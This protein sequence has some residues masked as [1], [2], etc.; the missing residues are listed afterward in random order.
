M[1]HKGALNTLGN[2]IAVIGTGMDIVYPKENYDLYAQ[3]LENGLAISE[4]IV[5]TRPNA[6]N[7]PMRNR[8]V[9]ALSNGVFVVEAT[10]NSGALI[11]VDFALEQGKNIYALPNSI[12]KDLFKK[13]T[14]AME[15]EYTF[16]GKEYK[17]TIPAGAAEDNDIPWY[18]PLYL[19]MR[20]GK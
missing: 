8:I 3:I 1:A 17:V 15:L 18:G 14:V 19:Q 12:M 4:F 16:E 13:K 2:T 7:F 9:S 5:G 11:T 10:E 6:I 20:Y